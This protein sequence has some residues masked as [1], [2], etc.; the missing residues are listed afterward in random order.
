MISLPA[1][2]V[3]PTVTVT[4]LFAAHAPLTL[5]RRSNFPLTAA[6]RN[7]DRDGLGGAGESQGRRRHPFRTRSLPSAASHVAKVRKLFPD[8]AEEVSRL[9][10]RNETFRSLCE[11]YGLASDALDLLEVMNRPQDVDKMHEY[12]G[13][14]KDLQK[15]L[16]SELLASHDHDGTQTGKPVT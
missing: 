12:R 5:I 2:G 10:L 9:A 7:Q 4:C 15:E 16:K 3:T 11:E 6:I 14:V 13:I 8:R 1:E